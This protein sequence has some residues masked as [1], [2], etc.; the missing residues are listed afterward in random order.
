MTQSPL[1]GACLSSRVTEQ[2]CLSGVVGR[3]GKGKHRSDIRWQT[4]VQS[5]LYKAQLVVGY[6]LIDP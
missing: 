3:H 6:Q 5:V 4:G 2:T 1:T